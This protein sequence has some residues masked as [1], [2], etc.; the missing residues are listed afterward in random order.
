M[1]EVDQINAANATTRAAFGQV[2][3]ELFDHNDR[4]YIDLLREAGMIKPYFT[5]TEE[6]ELRNALGGQPFK[7]V[8][9]LKRLEE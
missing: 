9:P 1:L 8:A 5:T 2:F 3:N 4:S 7:P 6:D